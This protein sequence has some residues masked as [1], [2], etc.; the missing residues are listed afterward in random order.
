MDKADHHRIRELA[1]EIVVNFHGEGTPE[2]WEA[3]RAAA[4]NPEEAVQLVYALARIA[5]YLAESIE[6]ST[7][8][9]AETVVRS[10]HAALSQS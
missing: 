3:T 10:A 5:T 1:A 7:G 4:Q 6:E 8:E 9:R 2:E